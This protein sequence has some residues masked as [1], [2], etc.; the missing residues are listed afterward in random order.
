MKRMPF[1]APLIVSIVEFMMERDR[2]Y[3]L[4]T[5]VGLLALIST[6]CST[7]EIRY[8]LPGRSIGYRA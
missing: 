8:A 3:F 1:R 2:L 5:V 7:R 6:A 4:L